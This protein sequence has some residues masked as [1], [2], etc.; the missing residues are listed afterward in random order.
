MEIKKQAVAGTL[1]SSDIMITVEKGTGAGIEIE[2]HSTVEQ[3]FGDQIRAIITK[4]L[5]K[6][7]VTNVH[8][9]AVDK[10]A[11]DCTVKARVSAAVYRAC[12]SMQYNWGGT[13]DE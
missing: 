10:G 1:E 6:L 9:T 12:Q 2:L 11:S 5:N 13:E 8:V 3:Q 7:K 4:T